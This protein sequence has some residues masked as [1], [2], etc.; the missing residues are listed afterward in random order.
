MAGTWSDHPSNQ[1]RNPPADA[2]KYA[3]S[4]SRITRLYATSIRLQKMPTQVARPSPRF[5]QVVLRVPTA[6]KRP[7]SMVHI[8]AGAVPWRAVDQEERH[9]GHLDQV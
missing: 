1:A 7:M 4:G 6:G 8:T 5:R 9:Q 3:A 2:A